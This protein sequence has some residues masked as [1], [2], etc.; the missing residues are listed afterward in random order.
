MTADITW[1]EPQIVADLAT[2]RAKAPLTHCLTNSVVTGFTANALLAI[3]AAPAM[4]VD[5]EEAG[6]FAGIAQGLLINL[7]TITGPEAAVFELAAAAA[8]Q[9][10]T[11]W[12]LDPVA[13]GV[14]PL[15]TRTALRLLEQRPALIRGNAS[16]ILALAGAAGG[17]RGVDSTARSD[18]ALPAARHL[19]QQS[20]AVVAVSGAID[21]VTNGA[22]VVAIP[23]GHPLMTKVTGTGCA[24]GAVMAAFVGALREPWR[25]ALAASAI[26]AR[27][28]E[29]AAGQAQ[30]PGSFAVS[31]L[32]QLA[33]IGT[34]GD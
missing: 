4:V 17:G 23:G 10:A 25:A 14:L 28:G 31:F 29:R 12:V 15:R 13:V 7:G 6:L 3:G 20:G 19:A 8:R 22:E 18:E 21:Y 24:L 11:P 26:F 32:D 16:E 2:L 33:L 34:T 9:A 27:A 30:G 1:P 5:A